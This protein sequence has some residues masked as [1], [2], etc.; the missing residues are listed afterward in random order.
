MF[1]LLKNAELYSPEYLGKKDI[2]VCAG[3]IVAIE[4]KVD[5]VLPGICRIIDR[6]GAIVGPGLIDRD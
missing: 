2:L 3:K 1:L 5:Q 4:D 6:Q